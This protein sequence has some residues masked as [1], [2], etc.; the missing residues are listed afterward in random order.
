MHNLAS[1]ILFIERQIGK[2]TSFMKPEVSVIVPTYNS[3]KYLT[4]ALKSVFNQ[5]YSNF[6][7][8]FDD[9]SGVV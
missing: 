5:S 2:N 4:K 7:I 6:E 3:E 1:Y 9:R 8:I